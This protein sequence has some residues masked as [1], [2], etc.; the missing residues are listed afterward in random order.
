MIGGPE[1]RFWKNR[2]QQHVRWAE[3]ERAKKSCHEER[4]M[5]GDKL[6]MFIEIDGMDQSKCSMPNPGRF[7]VEYT[8]SLYLTIKFIR[9]DKTLDGLPLLHT[10]LT[11]VMQIAPGVKRWK[12]YTWFD[13]YPAGSDVIMTVL[14]DV[15]ARSTEQD[16]Q[17]ETLYLYA[18]N[19]SR[20]NKNKSFPLLISSSPTQPLP[21][22]PH[23]LRTRYMLALL[24]ILVAEGIFKKIKFCLLPKG[25]SFSVIYRAQ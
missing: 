9:L 10:H 11:G 4:A 21:T 12:A 22:L 16:L 6:S 20:E 3:M 24:N 7:N 14:L 1:K 13:R 15:L 8:T 19:C 5:R 25:I 2:H 23:H 17:A 18:D